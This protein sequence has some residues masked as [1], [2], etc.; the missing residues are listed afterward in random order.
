MNKSSKLGLDYEVMAEKVLLF[1]GAVPDPEGSIAHMNAHQSQWY[2]NDS[3]YDHTL[4]DG[5]TRDDCFIEFSS[6][7]EADVVTEVFKTFTDMYNMEWKNK[8]W[9]QGFKKET[10]QY[11]GIRYRDGGHL[12]SHKDQPVDYD[13]GLLNIC[14]YLNDDYDGGEIG[15][16]YIDIPDYKP[17]RGD[18]M[19]F[20]GHFDHYGARATNGIKYMVC[21]KMYVDGE[22]VQPLVE[23]KS[24]DYVMRVPDEIRQKLDGY[25]E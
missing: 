19:V 7:E 25:G 12:G 9:E 8:E 16:D 4:P 22:G 5:V 11:N 3:E 21:V 17:K 14:M 2:E 6:Q 24:F 18:V 10:V 13:I 23:K 15:F 1:P 20:P